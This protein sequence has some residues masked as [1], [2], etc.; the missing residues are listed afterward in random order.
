[1]SGSNAWS[2]SRA[3]YWPSRDDGQRLLWMVREGIR[4]YIHNTVL[5]THH[6]ADDRAPSKVSRY[7][8]HWRPAI[9]GTDAITS[10]ST[11]ASFGRRATS[12][13]VLAGRD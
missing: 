9:A 13:V 12:T 7:A 1:M 8:C 4:P 6:K 5:R 2:T 10:T 3:W 11:K